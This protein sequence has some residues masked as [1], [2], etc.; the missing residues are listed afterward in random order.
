MGHPVDFHKMH[1]RLCES[2]HLCGVALENC[3]AHHII[4]YRRHLMLD[5]FR[6]IAGIGRIHTDGLA[7]Q[8]NSKPYAAYRVDSEQTLERFPF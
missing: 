8:L 4:W 5:Y 3:K 1:V 2:C 7:V 6:Q